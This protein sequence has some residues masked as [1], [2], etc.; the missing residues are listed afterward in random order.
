MSEH[1]QDCMCHNCLPGGPAD[2]SKIS[3][4]PLPPAPHDWQK[5]FRDCEAERDTLKSLCEK[6]KGYAVH[7]SMCHV[8][9]LSKEKR[10]C[11]CG[12]D[13]LLKQGGEVLNVWSMTHRKEILGKDV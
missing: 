3:G 13:E 4:G 1:S 9:H 8:H 7:T 11:N 10:K 2:W 6:L 12:L 5:Q